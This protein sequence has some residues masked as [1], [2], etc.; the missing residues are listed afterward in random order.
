MGKRFPMAMRQAMVRRMTGPEAISAC[1]LARETGICQQT[2]SRWRADAR[3]NGVSEAERRPQDWTP[4]E[5]LAFV[6]EAAA[7]P[8]RELG[9]FLRRRGVHRAQLEDWRAR[10]AAGLA[11]PAAPRSGSS[12][13]ARRIRELEREL[14]R[15]EKALAEAA[16]L[17]VLQKKVR[18]IWGDEDA[19]TKPPSDGESSN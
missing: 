5:V 4:E 18:A 12:P 9:G 8:D 2:L 11:E 10:L 15:K 13:E 16:A 1:A 3:L 6:V 17:L 7:I 19:S 14:Q